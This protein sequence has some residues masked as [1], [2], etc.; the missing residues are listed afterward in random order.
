MKFSKRMLGVYLW[1]S[2]MCQEIKK[3][4]SLSSP[5]SKEACLV[6]QAVTPIGSK[7]PPTSSS[8]VFLL[9]FFYNPMVEYVFYVCIIYYCFCQYA[10][11]FRLYFGLPYFMTS[12]T[13]SSAPCSLTFNQTHHHRLFLYNRSASTKYPKHKRH[14]SFIKYKAVI[15]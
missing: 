4:L 7:S 14:L 15:L 2:I 3:M 13:R 8:R 10:C 9:F 11:F 6:T 1:F 5:S 12:V